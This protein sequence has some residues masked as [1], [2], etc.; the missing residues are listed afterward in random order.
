[1]IQ[2]FRDSVHG[3]QAAKQKHPGE[4]SKATCCMAGKRESRRKNA[5]EKEATDEI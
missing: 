2:S 1:M 4:R 5:R 3:Q